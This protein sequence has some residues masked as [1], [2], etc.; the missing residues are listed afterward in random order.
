MASAVHI[1]EMHGKQL[2]KFK[3]IFETQRADQKIKIDD[4]FRPAGLETTIR[5]RADNQRQDGMT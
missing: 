1:P 3:S 4:H 2:A 5:D